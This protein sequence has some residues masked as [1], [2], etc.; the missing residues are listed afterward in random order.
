M[1][2]KRIT[3]IFSS[4]LMILALVACTPKTAAANANI[5]I[6]AGDAG[7][8]ITLNKG[9]VLVVALNGNTTTGYNWFMQPMEPSILKQVGDPVYTPETNRLGAAGTIALTFQAIETGQSNMTLN[10][11][12]SFEKGIVPQ[13]TFEVTVVVK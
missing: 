7:K 4:I 6:G 1:N 3:L 13:N 12:R 11:A 10:Y 2:T 8:T 9:D 5:S